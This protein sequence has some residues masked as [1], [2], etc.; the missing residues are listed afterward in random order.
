MALP[1][2]V[3]I[4]GQSYQLCVYGNELRDMNDA[5]RARLRAEIERDGVLV[6]VLVDAQRNVIDGRHRLSIAS[7]IGI[8]RI[9]VTTLAE[10]SPEE[11]GRL[12]LALNSARRHLSREDQVKAY[13]LAVS[14]GLSKRAAAEAAGLDK[15]TAGRLSTGANAPVDTPTPARPKGRPKKMPKPKLKGK[16]GKRRPAKRPSPE[17]LAK[18]REEARALRAQGLTQREIAAK[19][20]VAQSQ[21]SLDL[22]GQP[23]PKS[24]P[25][26]AGVQ[27]FNQSLIARM[28]CAISELEDVAEDE[29]LLKPYFDE[30]IRQIRQA[31]QSLKE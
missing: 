26:V 10:A 3:E 20:G 29:P 4:Q 1:E 15:R 24:D 5:E 7:E 8:D 19:L 2:V 17:D 28:E 13:E 14:L 31:I 12:A 18:R 23:K 25:A 30:A 6:D 21:V 16:D 27:R 11:C 22:K 9:P